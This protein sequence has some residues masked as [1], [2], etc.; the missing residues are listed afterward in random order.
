MC[1]CAGKRE[2][3]REREREKVL[4]SPRMILLILEYL[5][6]AVTGKR[7]VTRSFDLLVNQHWQN[8][9]VLR[10]EQIQVQFPKIEFPKCSTERTI[11]NF[12]TLMLFFGTEVSKKYTSLK[13][14]KRFYKIRHHLKN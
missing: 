12:E 7:L 13:F 2:R 4:I 8:Y 9:D 6:S 10:V 1:V 3:E 14:R 5:F 11:S